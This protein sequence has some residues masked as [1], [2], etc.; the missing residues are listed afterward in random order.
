MKIAVNTR[1]L[2][3][4]KLDG[5]GWFTYE[6][7]NYLTKKHS[8]HEFVFL[9]DRPF[10]NEFIFSENVTPVVI[11][12]PA[13]HPFL[14]LLWFEYSVP[15]AL[16]KYNADLFLSQ[17]GYLSL[18]TKVPSIAVIHDINFEHYPEQ[19]PWLT[20]TYYR[21]F[22][23]KYAHKSHRLV[24]VSEFSKSDISKKY[25]VDPLNIDVVYNGINN[26]YIPVSKETQ[27]EIRNKFTDGQPYFLFLGTIHPRKNIERMLLAFDR[28]KK[29]S[30]SGIKLLIVGKKMWWTA[31]MESTYND[32]EYKKDVEF[33]GRLDPVEKVRD[34][35]ASALAM[36]YVPV[37]EGFGI[38]IIESQAC[39]VPVITS[40]TSSLPEVAGEAAILCDPFSVESIQ[41]AMTD[42][43]ENSAKREQLIELGNINTRRFSWEQTAEKLWQ[44]IEKTLK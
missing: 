38:P 13:R 41:Y 11:S 10:S 12:P 1:L 9:F 29:Q 14:W 36:I 39:G 22:F 27:N 34:L 37:F 16:R 35:L 7:L 23:P 26:L 30:R 5:I 32:L 25:G 40:N 42:M 17:D 15:N 44:T 18:R 33:L 4:D 3:K 43:V 21:Y 31:Q 24:T 6:T 20:R 2:L 28:F 8:E 19:L